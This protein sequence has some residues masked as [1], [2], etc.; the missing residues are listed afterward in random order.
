MCFMGGVRFCLIVLVVLRGVRQDFSRFGVA[1]A[2][3]FNYLF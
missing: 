2:V 3:I 1:W